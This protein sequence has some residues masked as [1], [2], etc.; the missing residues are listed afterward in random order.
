MDFRP[1]RD[2]RHEIKFLLNRSQQVA[3]VEELSRHLQPDAHGEGGQYAVTSLYYDTPDYKAYWDKVDGFK[4]RRKVRLRVYG[5][6]AVLPA[7][8]VFF[9]IKARVGN[10]MGKRRLRLS[11][12]D[13]LVLAGQADSVA[14]ANTPALHDAADQRVFDE[15]HYLFGALRLRPTCVVSYQR[16]AYGAHED[17]P[18]LRIT[19]DT[20]V[21]CHG[22][23]LSLLSADAGTMHTVLEPGWSILEVKVNQTIPFWLGE[24]L[25]RHHCTP[26]R[27]SKYCASLE[28]CG[29]VRRRQ[30]ILIHNGR[31]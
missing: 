5:D 6:Q 23:N 7:T 26:R 22:E 25:S 18:D 19:F 8:P 20:D 21:R 15:L 2:L 1:K 31:S 4:M 28:R 3:L 29:A 30:H 13:A 10:R 16:L 9:E 24:L 17:Y 14:S 27:I 12:A 11:Y